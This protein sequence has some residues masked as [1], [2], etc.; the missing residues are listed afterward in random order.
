[1]KQSVNMASFSLKITKI[2]NVLKTLNIVCLILF[3]FSCNSDDDSSSEIAPSTLE[4]L[5]NGKWYLE[6]KTPGG[7]SDCEKNSSFKFNANHTVDVENFDDSSGP[8]D[9]LGTVNSTYSLSGSVLTIEL[10]SDSVT[11]TINSISETNL[12]VTNNV[13]DTIVFDKVQG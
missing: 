5:T 2:M 12:N 13:G 3:A 11:A 9:T 10:G 7:F 4:L 1:M 8:C 6:S